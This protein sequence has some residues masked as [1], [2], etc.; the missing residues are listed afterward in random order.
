MVTIEEIYFINRKC[1][2]YSF[3]FFNFSD[4]QAFNFHN[5]INI[6]IDIYKFYI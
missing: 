5:F 2:S 1:N 3:M 6:S 4:V